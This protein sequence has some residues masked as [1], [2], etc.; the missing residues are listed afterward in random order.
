M[1]T[2]RRRWRRQGQRCCHRCAIQLA[3]LIVF[4]LIK[5]V[6][7]VQHRRR[8]QRY[9]YRDSLQVNFPPVRSPPGFGHPGQTPPD[10]MPYAVKSPLGQ[11]PPPGQNV[12]LCI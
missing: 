7:A 8:R 6:T 1:P 10:K 12:F 5:G 3:S 2:R 9:R 4:D 11:I